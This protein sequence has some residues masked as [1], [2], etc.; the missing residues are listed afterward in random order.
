MT[1]EGMFATILA[2]IVL[3][4]VLCIGKPDIIDGIVYQLF[5]GNVPVAQISK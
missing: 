1:E 3:V 4:M 5:E 2:L